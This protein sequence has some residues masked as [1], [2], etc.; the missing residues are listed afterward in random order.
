M[1][2]EKMRVSLTK[3]P[4]K[5]YGAFWAVGLEIRGT[6]YKIRK[7]ERSRGARP[8]EKKQEAAGRHGPPARARRSGHYHAMELGFT[9][10]T[11]REK[12]KV[13]ANSPRANSWPGKGSR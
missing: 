8:P 6:D 11:H 5:G 9:I 12:E 3:P 4:P 13:T 10:Q 7:R 1:I 2:R